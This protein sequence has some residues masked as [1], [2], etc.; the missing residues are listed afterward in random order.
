VQIEQR[1]QDGI[2]VLQVDKMPFSWKETMAGKWLLHG[3][4]WIKDGYCVELP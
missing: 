2:Q 1:G 4:R 3:P